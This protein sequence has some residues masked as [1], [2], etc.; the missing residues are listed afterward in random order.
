M[1]ELSPKMTPTFIQQSFE[2]CEYHGHLLTKI[3]AMIES[4]NK[5]GTWPSQEALASV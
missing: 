2:T 5:E 1:A 3:D 4:L